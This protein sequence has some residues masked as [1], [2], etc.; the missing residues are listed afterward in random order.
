MS[1]AESEGPTP[2]VEAH[3]T[4]AQSN[5]TVVEDEADIEAHGITSNVNETLV[6]DD[7]EPES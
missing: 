1:S 2:E 5:E 6:G 4:E 7:T 3:G